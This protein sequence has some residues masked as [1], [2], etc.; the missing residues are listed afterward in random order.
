MATGVGLR[1]AGFYDCAGG[2]QVVVEGGIAYIG[3]MRAPHGTSVVDVRDPKN[4]KLLATLEMVPGTHSHKVRTANGLMVINQELNHNDP[5]PGPEGWQGGIRIF[6][7]STPSKPRETTRW[8][9]DAAEACIVSIS[10]AATSNVGHQRGYVGNIMMIW[11]CRASQ[12]DGSRRWWMPVNGRRGETRLGE[13]R[14]R[15]HH[16]CEW[17]IDYTSY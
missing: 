5:N 7:V 16:P 13:E 8:S 6:D 17:G 11:T 10:M 12:A 3:H 4:P 2:G 1:Q 14:H 9:T 15:C